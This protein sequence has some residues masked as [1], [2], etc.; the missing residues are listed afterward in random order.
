M[1][2]LTLRLPETLHQK[3]ERLAR[4]ES[5]SLHQYILDALKRQ[6]ASAY[7]V[8]PVSDEEATRQ[9]ATALL[10]RLGQRTFREIEKALAEQEK[11]KPEKGLKKGLTWP[12]PA[13]IIRVP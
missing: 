3:L 1:S 10:Q 12:P 11:V 13:L 8:Q 9:Q 2:R 5:V 4:R 6:A 7:K